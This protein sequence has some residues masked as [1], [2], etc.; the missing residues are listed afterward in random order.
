M[1]TPPLTGTEKN[2]WESVTDGEDDENSSFF[3]VAHSRIAVLL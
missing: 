1:Q 2:C 3:S